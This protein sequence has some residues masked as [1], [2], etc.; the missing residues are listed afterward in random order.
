MRKRGKHFHH[1]FVGDKAKFSKSFRYQCHVSKSRGLKFWGV[2]VLLWI[3][4]VMDVNHAMLA[5]LKV[6]WLLYVIR[7]EDVSRMQGG[8]HVTVAIACFIFCMLLELCVVVARF[9]GAANLS[10]GYWCSKFG[11]RTR[12][13]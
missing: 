11:A 10:R 2:F 13:D 12:V 6:Y 1:A 3:A 8:R 5:V 4:V 9:A 7:H